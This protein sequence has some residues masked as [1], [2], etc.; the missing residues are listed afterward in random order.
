MELYASSPHIFVCCKK[1]DIMWLPVSNTA[2][3]RRG[4][5]YSSIRSTDESVI[6]AMPSDVSGDTKGEEE[7]PLADP[8]VVSLK[9]DLLQ[10]VSEGVGKGYIPVSAEDK[11]TIED[12]VV[13]FEEE[14]SYVQFPRQVSLCQVSAG[15]S[16]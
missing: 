14:G 13:E 8:V 16:L 7:T 10:A 12:L 4:R 2:S 9:S 6:D 11:K 3:G 5:T 1:N 15:K